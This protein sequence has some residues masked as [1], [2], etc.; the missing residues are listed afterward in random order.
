MDKRE[1][2]IEAMLDLVVERGFHNAPMSLTVI[3]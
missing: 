3:F 2:I 1:S